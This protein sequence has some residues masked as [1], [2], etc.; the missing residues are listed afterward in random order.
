MTTKINMRL[1]VADDAIAMECL[2]DYSGFFTIGFDI[3]W[4]D[5]YPHWIVAEI[6]GTV[7]GAIE[8]CPGKPIGRLEFLMI[9]PGLSHTRRA[10]V[11]MQLIYAGMA[12]LRQGGSQLCCWTVSFEQKSYRAILEKRGAETTLQANIMY[13]RLDG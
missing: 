11:T 8:V 12:T 6:D 7:V 4:S 9:G 2:A 5:I 10:K 13:K 1:A 3:D